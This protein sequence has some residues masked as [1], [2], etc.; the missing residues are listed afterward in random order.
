MVET[1]LAQI[2]QQVSQSVKSQGQFPG[3]TEANPK[4]QMNALTLRNGK[5]LEE[6]TNPK[7]IVVEDEAIVIED[8]DK[9]LEEIVV[10][11]KQAYEK[12]ASLTPPRVY[13]PPVPFPQRLA[14][15]KLEQKYGKC[16]DILKRMHINIPF[17][18]AI[19]EIPSYGKF[20]KELLSSKKKLGASTTINLPKECSAILLNK[21]P[22]KLD[23]PGSFSIPCSIGGIYIQRALYDLG[24]S[25]SLM[26][27][28]IFKRL[29][30]TDLKPTR[31]SLQLVHRSVKFPLGVI[32]DVPLAIGKLV[33]PCDFLV[34]DIS[35]DT[36]VPIILGRPCLATAGA[37]IDV[38]SGKLLLQV[39]VDKVDFE[40]SETMGGPSMSDSSYRVDVLEEYLSEPSLER[41]SSDK[42]QDCLTNIDSEDVEL[43]AYA[44]LLLGSSVGQKNLDFT[45]IKMKTRTR[46]IFHN[47]LQN[48][49]NQQGIANNSAIIQVPSLHTQVE[50]VPDLTNQR[51]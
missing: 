4:G 47:Q 46:T 26:P 28:S 38:R 19:F 41:T 9:A 51:M 16:L 37:M 50:R 44:W 36:Q 45:D 24:A 25:V 3:N 13:I 27:L 23:D 18:E 17:L 20:L 43:L 12:E 48:L 10:E 21:L 31:V 1:Q 11:K 39:G 34:M 14:K 22:Q 40:L 6:T 30:M 33:I 5:V 15:A 8:E 2:A 42:L 32:E 7:S 29:Q 35:E 49:P